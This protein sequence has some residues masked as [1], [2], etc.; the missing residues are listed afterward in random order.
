MRSGYRR[1]PG[2]GGGG[3]GGQKEKEEGRGVGEREGCVESRG[4]RP[5]AGDAGVMGQRLDWV[6][7]HTVRGRRQ[8]LRKF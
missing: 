6:R 3:G 7:P 1:L 2:G 5:G 8:L 4:K